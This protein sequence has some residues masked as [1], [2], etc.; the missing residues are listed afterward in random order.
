[1]RRRG[2]ALTSNFNKLVLL[3]DILH[4]L[5]LLFLLGSIFLHGGD[6]VGNLCISVAIR[7]PESQT[8][9]EMSRSILEGLVVLPTDALAGREEVNTKI[10]PLPLITLGGVPDR[11]DVIRNGATHDGEYDSRI[12]DIDDDA[13]IA[14]L[15]RELVVALVRLEPLELLDFCAILATGGFSEAR[16]A[17]LLF[18][19][20][21]LFLMGLTLGLVLF[22]LL[23]LAATRAQPRAC[24]VLGSDRADLRILLLLLRC[25]L[26]LLVIL[27][28]ERG[29]IGVSGS[30]S[31]EVDGPVIGNADSVRHNQG[32]LL[33][34][35]VLSLRILEVCES[36][37]DTK[38]HTILERPIV[39]GGQLQSGILRLQ[40]NAIA[41]AFEEVLLKLG[42]FRL[43]KAKGFVVDVLGH[44]TVANLFENEA[45][46][47][48]EEFVVG[49][50]RL[51]WVHHVRTGN[52]G[53]VRFVAQTYPSD[54][55]TLMKIVVAWLGLHLQV[56]LAA[57][58]DGWADNPVEL[59]GV[60]VTG[61][62]L[63]ARQ[64]DVFPEL[65][66]INLAIHLVDQGTVLDLLLLIE[67]A[68]DFL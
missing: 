40:S 32:I 11:V 3:N 17:L 9:D 46:Y 19:L 52:V 68:Q 49:L 34:V 1:M 27:E 42:L 36:S 33:A 28:K 41:N 65:F 67:D 64:L 21:Q 7:R 55:D 47:G 25:W 15:G 66:V 58:V 56:E 39:L 13:H 14:N 29:L 18:L 43:D 24:Y 31:A 63:P 2:G 30:F 51:V 20:R 45:V 57:A 38:R 54:D 5:L 48:E 23:L 62:L 61:K 4:V 12:L 37:R 26:S 44:S 10:R 22:A 6:L 8:T 16:L 53:T 50:L 35:L 60:E 59:L